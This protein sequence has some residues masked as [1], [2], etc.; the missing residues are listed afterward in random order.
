MYEE[1]NG[2]QFGA[3]HSGTLGDYIDCP[4]REGTAALTLERNQ[5]TPG[6]LQQHIDGKAE[7]V[8]MPKRWEYSYTINLE[9]I[10]TKADDGVAATQGALGRML[11]V[12]MGGQVLGTGDT[13]N[14]AGAT[15]TDFDVTTAA[16]FAEGR[17]AGFATGTGSTLECREVEVVSGANLLLKEALTAAPA[18]ASDVYNSA[19]YYMETGDGDVVTSAQFIVEGLELQDRWILMGGQVTAMSFDLTPGGI[20]SATFTWRGVDWL[21]GDDGAT[22]LTASA[23]ANATYA[24]NTSL[25]LVDSEFHWGTNGTT[26]LA[27][28]TPSSFTFAPNI[29]Y[30]P[31]NSPGGTNNVEHWV[32]VHAAPVCSGTFT[33]PYEDHTY[34]DARDNRTDHRVFL[35]IGTSTTDGA[36][37]LSCPTVQVTNV[38]RV[39]VNGVAGQEV[40][41]EARLDAEANPSTD[42]DVSQSALRIHIF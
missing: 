4:I 31:I 13:I 39:N 42:T 7:N 28:I 29:T 35:Q 38:Q 36:I 20:P 23:L 15:T 2:A 32:R 1:T 25:V 21:H 6:H 5:E 14:D 8:L 30:A 10:D 24:D 27:T 19:C 34:L 3:D 41:W 12:A 26:T 18:N 17:A 16:L 37:C 11:K 9:T 22:D 33:L 40:S